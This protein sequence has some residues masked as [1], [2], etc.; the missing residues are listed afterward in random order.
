MNIPFA[1]GRTTSLQIASDYHHRK[2]VLC[3]KV[4]YVGGTFRYGLD[5]AGRIGV[6]VAW[7]IFRK[8]SQRKRLFFFVESVGRAPGWAP[9]VGYTPFRRLCVHFSGHS[10]GAVFNIDDILRL[11]YMIYCI[12]KT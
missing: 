1:E 2:G 10:Y 7:E 3:P 8:L 6:G 12:I 11:Q 9:L 5:P 4:I